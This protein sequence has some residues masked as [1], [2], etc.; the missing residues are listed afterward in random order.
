M[1]PLS[2]SFF[3]RPTLEVAPDL[4]GALLVHEPASGERR[5]GRIVEVEVYT[6][7]DPAW[8][9]WGIV[10]PATGLMVPEGRGLDFFGK[11]GTAYVYLCYG[12]YWMLNVVTE[13][14]G[15]AGCVFIRAVEPLEGR[16]AMWGRRETARREVDLTNGP[17]KLTQAFALDRRFHGKLLTAPP[18]Y[19]AEDEEKRDWPV[20]TSAR[21]GLHFGIDLPYR[22]FLK[23][24]RFVSPGVPSDVA[25]RARRAKKRGM[26][27]RR[28][29]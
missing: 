18:L 24:H 22:F 26:V 29:R 28:G 19:F 6:Q 2:P 16:Q 7:D 1:T 14:E 23:G 3:A 9:S 12:R 8:R 5:V 27:N 13:P 10:D 21:I 17:G 25:A 15:R 4:L 20:A 11:P